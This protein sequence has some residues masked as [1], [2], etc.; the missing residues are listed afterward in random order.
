MTHDITHESA[1]G[2]QRLMLLP[3]VRV[4]A[5][6]PLK[7]ADL[8][9]VVAGNARCLV[10]G[11]AVRLSAGDVFLVSPESPVSGL[12]DPN[13]NLIRV[14]FDAQHALKFTSG[15]GEIPGCRAFFEF[16][17]RLR[18]RHGLDARLRLMPDVLPRIVEMLSRL[19]RELEDKEP[20]FE[21]LSESLFAALVVDLAR[22]YA[23][24]AS[25]LCESLVRI[26]PVLAW[27]DEHFEGPVALEGIV[28]VSEMSQ[29]TMQRC[30]RRCFGMSP[31]S[32]L[33]HLRMTKAQVLLRDTEAKVKEI[34]PSVGILDANYF[35]R[36]FRQ[37]AGVEPTEYRAR[38]RRSLAPSLAGSL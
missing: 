22:L 18:T 23:K 17:P 13:L 24:Q 36:R 29:S 38:F 37:H 14:R 34:A 35:A 3:S 7:S 8:V 9:L 28:A 4:I 31:F 12:D 27:L 19:E 10:E 33:L 11:Q 2:A 1:P 32:Y 25:P 5:A 30:F 6:K 16:E 21:A 15:L 26:S 20:G